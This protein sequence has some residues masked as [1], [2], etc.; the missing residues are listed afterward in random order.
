M[1]QS[2]RKD[3]RNLFQEMMAS[4]GDMKSHRDGKLTLRTYVID[5]NPLPP[6]NAKIIR[7]TRRQYRMSRAVFAHHLRT[8]VRT[9]E[10]WEQGRSKP[11]DQA[12]SL[13]WMVRKYPDTL[14]RLK[15]LGD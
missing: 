2:G 14:S 5:L 15:T 12:A 4:L 8:S 9:L 13:I 10:L 1:K 3:K 11:N 7:E 6:L